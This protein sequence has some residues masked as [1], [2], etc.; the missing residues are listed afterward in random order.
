MADSPKIIAGPEGF[1]DVGAVHHEN[2]RVSLHT[3][4]FFPPM[5]DD[6]FA[7]G[8]IAAAN[9]LSDIYASGAVPSVVLNLAGF[10]KD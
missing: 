7:Y 1:D 6:P 8:A 5:V 10:P 3:V 4:D 2:G 9:A